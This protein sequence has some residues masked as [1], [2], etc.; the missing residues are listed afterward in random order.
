LP[1]APLGN[2]NFE[3]QSDS[4]EREFSPTTALKFVRKCVGLILW[5][6]RH[7]QGGIIT[8]LITQL[9]RSSLDREIHQVY[10][11]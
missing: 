11:C 8:K 5:G 6:F 2:W 1:T 10:S 3:F 9:M 4:E 7:S